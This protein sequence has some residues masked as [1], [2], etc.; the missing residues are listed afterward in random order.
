[1]KTIYRHITVAP[2][3]GNLCAGPATDDLPGVLCLKYEL[4]SS[5]KRYSGT[6]ML[7]SPMGLSKGYVNG[8]VTVLQVLTFYSLH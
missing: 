2:K 5:Q 7:R 8:E 3:P 1:M 4:S 6:S